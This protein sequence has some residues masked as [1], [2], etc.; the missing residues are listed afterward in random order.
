MQAAGRA[1]LAAA[2]GEML[3]VAERRFVLAQPRETRA[4]RGGCERQALAQRA[5][6]NRLD[7]EV[8][9]G[10]RNIDGVSAGARNIGAGAQNLIEMGDPG[11]GEKH[12]V[13][14]AAGAAVEPRPTRKRLDFRKIWGARRV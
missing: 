11:A 9:A 4:G 1:G 6:K 5:R 13:S 7:A 8:F 2:A 10:I 14:D 12:R 3:G